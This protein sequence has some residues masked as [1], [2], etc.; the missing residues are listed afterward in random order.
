MK[1]KLA[2]LQTQL[3]AEVEIYLILQEAG[4]KV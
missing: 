3:V 1:K 4:N 2:N